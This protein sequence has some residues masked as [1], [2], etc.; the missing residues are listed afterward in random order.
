MKTI[1]LSIA[2]IEAGARSAKVTP[3]RFVSDILSISRGHRVCAHIKSR[4]GAFAIFSF[5]EGVR[6]HHTSRG[7]SAAPSDA[8]A[9]ELIPGERPLDAIMA[10]PAM[11][12]AP[13][14]RT[15]KAVLRVA[16]GKVGRAER[17][18]T[19]GGR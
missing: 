15:P 19:K 5:S 12:S 13:V 18:D 2:T 4:S 11:K 9:Y 1:K 16:R 8:V 17:G 7:G 10:N 6:T 3:E 14:Y